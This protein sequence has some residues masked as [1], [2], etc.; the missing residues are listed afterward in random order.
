MGTFSNINLVDHCD[1]AHSSPSISVKF[2]G[3]DIETISIEPIQREFLTVGCHVIRQNIPLIPCWATKV[4]GLSLTAAV[5]CLSSDI[6]AP[7]MAYVALSRVTSLDGLF[8]SALDENAIN[9][10][11][12]GLLEYS[13]QR[14][15]THK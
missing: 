7:S 14:K 1:D 9:L 15:C 6:F 2:D 10:H 8:L 11:E 3:T 12:K 5:I 4:Q 13:H